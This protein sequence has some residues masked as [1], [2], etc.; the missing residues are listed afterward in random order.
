MAFAYL[1]IAGAVFALAVSVF[2]FLTS[3]CKT[4]WVALPLGLI[5]FLAGLLAVIAGVGV[6]A[7]NYTNIIKNQ[8]CGDALKGSAFIKSQYDPY[9]DQIMCTS[10][11]DC[12]DVDGNVKS[13]FSTAASRVNRT[14]ALTYTG[15]YTTYR[16]C[17]NALKNSSTGEANNTNAK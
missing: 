8:V 7:G 9:V 11:C 3:R 14:A 6:F 12:A 10:A 15:S 13:S 1:L 17:F 16:T 2:G 4:C 5:S